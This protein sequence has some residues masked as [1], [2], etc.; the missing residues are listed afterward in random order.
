[1]PSPRKTKSRPFLSFLKTSPCKPTLSECQSKELPL[2]P[3]LEVGPPLPPPNGA[4][5]TCPVSGQRSRM[6]FKD[7]AVSVSRVAIGA[8]A[9]V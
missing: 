9:N 8:I 1:M 6:G 3:P 4:P 5:P 2:L 7:E